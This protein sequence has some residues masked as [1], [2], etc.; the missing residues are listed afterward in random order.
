MVVTA[1]A[2]SPCLSGLCKVEE[3]QELDTAEDLGWGVAGYETENETGPE[4]ERP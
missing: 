3:Q 2:E 1:C 4:R